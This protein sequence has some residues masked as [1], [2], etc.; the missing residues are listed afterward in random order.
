MPAASAMRAA[1]LGRPAQER[2]ET[3]S[4]L[5]DKSSFMLDID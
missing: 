4:I 2:A 3:Q 5:L 1:L